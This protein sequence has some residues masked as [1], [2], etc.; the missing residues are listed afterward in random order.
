MVIEEIVRGKTTQVY[1]VLRWQ[2]PSCH[3]GVTDPREFPES[4]LRQFLV[5]RFDPHVTGI[6]SEVM[7]AHMIPSFHTLCM[8]TTSE[9]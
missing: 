7:T 2:I 8:R 6:L 4:F 1:N 9:K 5:Q 3:N